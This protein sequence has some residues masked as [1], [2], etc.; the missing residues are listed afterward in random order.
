[1]HK[2]LSAGKI[3]AFIIALAIA[4]FLWQIFFPPGGLAANILLGVFVAIFF[5]Y[6][7]VGYFGGLLDQEFFP[8]GS[9]ERARL[10]RS[11]DRFIK[12]SK[13]NLTLIKNSKSKRKKIGQKALDDF[14]QALIQASLIFNHV[15]KDWAN[16]NIKMSDHEKMLKEAHNSLEKASNSVF[17]LNRSWRF[18]YGMPSLIFALLCALLLREFV[19]EP[20]QIP[21]GSMIPSL[22]VGDHLF[23][24]KFHYGLSKP[25]TNDPDFLIKWR[26]PKPGDVVVFKSPGYVSSHA[27][28]PW[29]KRVIAT[30]GQTIQIINNLVYVNGEAYSHSNAGELVSYMDFSGAGSGMFDGKWHELQAL[31]TTEKIGTFEHLIHMPVPGS[32]FG[33]GSYWPVMDTSSLKGLK[34]SNNKCT[35]EPGFV[36][37]MG[38]NRAHSLDSRIWGALPVSRV[39]G[40]AL[41][42]WMSADGSGQSV[43]FGPFNLPKFRLDR[44]FTW[45]K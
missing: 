44:W 43:K 32:P 15:T 45:V 2:K 27:N 39:K 14:D 7:F 28:E 16:K 34:C 38:D 22:L 9:R 31:K 37:V 19:L 29:V 21:S 8:Q 35:V 3:V 20:Y 10:Y 6:Y 42:I 36:F 18:L 40:K 23:V 11:L 33:F 1:M 25:F 24:S 5:V 13:N 41:F 30:Q 17:S 12:E 4:G 26:E